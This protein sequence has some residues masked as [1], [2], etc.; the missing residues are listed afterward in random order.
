VANAVVL[1]HQR[2]VEPGGI[3]YV[4]AFVAPQPIQLLP[5]HLGV[6]RTMRPVVDSL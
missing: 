5:A 3:V 2:S 6:G 4:A 1:Q